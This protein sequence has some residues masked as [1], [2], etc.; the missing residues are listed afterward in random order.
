V[1]IKHTQAIPENTETCC[2]NTTIKELTPQEIGIPSLNIK[3][4][5]MQPGGYS[6][7][8][9][10]PELHRLLITGGKGTLSNGQKTL[11]LQ[12][13]DIVYIEPNEPHQLKT[14][15]TEPLKFVC[16]TMDTQT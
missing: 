14:V 13:G 10:H 7:L 12:T 6:P 9:Q 16:L 2:T 3:L 1:K 5:E 4:F 11:P 8:H 15:G